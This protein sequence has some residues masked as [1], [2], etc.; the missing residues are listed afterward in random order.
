MGRP[1][2]RDDFIQNRGIRENREQHNQAE[3]TAQVKLHVER[4][5]GEYEGLKESH[6]SH[7]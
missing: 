4:R 2:Q 7:D 6:C 3:R 1:L 5:H